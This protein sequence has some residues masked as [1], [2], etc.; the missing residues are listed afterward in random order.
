MRIL[1]L[2]SENSLDRPGWFLQWEQFT[3]IMNKHDNDNNAKNSETLPKIAMRI[4][5]AVENEIM[6]LA[7]EYAWASYF[8]YNWKLFWC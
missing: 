2:F 8:T 6:M 4:V 3:F 7:S 5:Y 1:R